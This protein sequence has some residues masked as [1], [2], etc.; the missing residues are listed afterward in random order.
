MEADSVQTANDK[1]GNMHMANV[2]E[3]V[4]PI[5][6]MC[7]ISSNILPHRVWNRRVNDPIFADFTAI[8]TRPNIA[9]PSQHHVD[10]IAD[11]HREHVGIMRQ[12]HMTS[13]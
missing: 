1:P 11:V 7:S 6:K 12:N 8:Q 9:P 10:E 2:L 4:R 3:Y 5:T 13:I